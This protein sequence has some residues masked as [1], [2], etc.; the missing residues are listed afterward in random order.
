[1]DCVE[2]CQEARSTTE[3]YANATYAAPHADLV[4][5][6]SVAFHEVVFESFMLPC[7]CR[8]MLLFMLSGFPPVP[9]LLHV[10]VIGNFRFS[11]YTVHYIMEQSTE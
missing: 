7:Y 5:L 4:L 9:M 2:Q 6:R 8:A 11:Q 3:E 1:M 10:H